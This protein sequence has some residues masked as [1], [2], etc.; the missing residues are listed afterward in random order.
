LDLDQSAR[1]V[2]A[3]GEPAAADKAPL[4]GPCNPGS[5]STAK[6]DSREYDLAAPFLVKRAKRIATAAYESL[7]YSYASA[8]ESVNINKLISPLRYDLIVRRDYYQFFRE[9]RHIFE[10]DFRSYAEIARDTPYYRWFRDVVS[11]RFSPHL[12]NDRDTLDAEFCRRLRNAA[13][14]HDSFAQRG[15]DAAWP[16]TLYAPKTTLPTES[17]KVIGRSLYAG[18]GCHRIALLMLD[19]MD[20]LPPEW[21]RLRVLEG[22]SP[23]DNTYLLISSLRLPLTTYYRFLSLGYAERP[24]DSRVE[25][26]AHVQQVAPTRLPELDHVL[27]IDEPALFA[28]ND[29]A[30]A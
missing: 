5:L 6:S 12:L 13:A 29:M 16:I 14:L 30:G 27:A 4:I 3:I 8:H 9:N 24:F 26:R 15:F 2:A 21:V 18:G 25:L 23:L 28:A 10:H 22:Y 19:G 20:E 11:R 1:T 7:R 17:G